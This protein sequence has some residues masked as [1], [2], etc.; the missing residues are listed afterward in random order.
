MSGV[1]ALLG[2]R[3]A[4]PKDNYA[5]CTELMVFGRS[6]ACVWVYIKANVGRDFVGSHTAEQRADNMAKFVP[7]RAYNFAEHDDAA[8]AEGLGLPQVDVAEYREWGAT[9]ARQI[10]EGERREIAGAA[11]DGCAVQ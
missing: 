7:P 8:I 9:L 11:P 2:V 10:D 3:P 1:D 4:N 5:G 6:R